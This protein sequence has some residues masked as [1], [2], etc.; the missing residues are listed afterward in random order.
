MYL[1]AAVTL[2]PGVRGLGRV[3]VVVIAAATVAACGIG[4]GS[5]ADQL[6]E[7]ASPS[8]TPAP[9]VQANLGQPVH[10]SASNL[11]GRYSLS[12]TPLSVQAEADST[13]RVRIGLLVDARCTSGSCLLGR[14]AF[15]LRSDA[16]SA[17]RC[18][19]DCFEPAFPDDAE[20]EVNG[21]ARGFLTWHVPV[22][23]YRLTYVL[24]G[25]AQ[26]VGWVVVSR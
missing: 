23:R 3:T 26:P 6:A 5:G 1:G 8:R 14:Q 24:D 2:L 17:A 16:A 22:G 21:A 19:D 13:G 25:V 11:Y 12:A 7:P 18:V 4:P 20:L 15:A 9:A 10:V